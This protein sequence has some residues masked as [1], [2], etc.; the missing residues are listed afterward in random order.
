[1]WQERA[2][3]ERSSSLEQPDAA[4]ALGLSESSVTATSGGLVNTRQQVGP[5][6]CL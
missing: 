2:G 5:C 4:G 6:L 3:R 1:M